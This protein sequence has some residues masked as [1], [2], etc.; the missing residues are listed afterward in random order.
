MKA[1]V[2]RVLEAS[3]VVE[4]NM[5]GKIG[6]GLLIYLGIIKGD[7]TTQVDAL[8]QKIVQFRVFPDEQY[9][10]NRSLVDVQGEALV[11]SQFT[12]ASDGKKGNRPSFDQAAS[13]EEALPL[14]EKFIKN[15][16]ELGIRTN[17]G[18]FGAYMQVSS[19]NYGPVTFILEK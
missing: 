10:M 11:I 14:Y 7:S 1:V 12:L 2:Q 16:K 6:Q 5:V 18:I 4:G 9:R 17:T 8:S 15:L 3:V 19:I 13:P